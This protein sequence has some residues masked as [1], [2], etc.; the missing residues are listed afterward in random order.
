MLIWFVSA[1]SYLLLGMYVCEVF[2]Y[3][4]WSK[5]IDHLAETLPIR[6]IDYKLVD[7]ILKVDFL[8]KNN[9][10]PNNLSSVRSPATAG[11]DAGS[12]LRWLGVFCLEIY[13][14]FNSKPN[15]S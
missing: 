3:P 10:T 11:P 4:V 8:A 1:R 5:H 12:G 15:A 7:Q 14:S 9:N 6:L 13:I 2:L